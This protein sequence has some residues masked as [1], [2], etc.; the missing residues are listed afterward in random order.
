MRSRSLG[1]GFGLLLAVLCLLSVLCL[2]LGCQRGAPEGSGLSLI[3][4]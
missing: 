1:P 4:I 3:H 2:A